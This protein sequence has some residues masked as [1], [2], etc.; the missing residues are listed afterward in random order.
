MAYQGKDQVYVDGQGGNRDPEGTNFAKLYGFPLS[1]GCL[2]QMSGYFDTNVADGLL[3]MSPSKMSFIHQIFDAGK[4]KAPI[5]GLC[6]NN[7]D[8]HV[9][10]KGYSAGALS[11]GGIEKGFN[12]SPL[13]W[14]KN[15]DPRKMSYRLYLER[16]YIR[17]G[18]GRSVVSKVPYSAYKTIDGDYQYVNTVGRGVYLDTGEP[19]T[20]MDKM[21]AEPF[22]QAWQAVTNTVYDTELLHI[23]EAD[24]K[25]LP[26]IVFQFT[27]SMYMSST[28]LL[29][30]RCK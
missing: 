16:M 6:F 26:T 24:Y 13:V 10:P 7:L 14:A 27:V 22:K 15:A 8:G 12:R 3:G 4:V 2:T 23:S 29:Y 1:F 11:L 18:G 9:I 28:V 30:F 20:I 5:F 25:A 17:P 19:Y 21:L